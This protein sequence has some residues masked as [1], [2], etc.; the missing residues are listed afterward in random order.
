MSHKEQTDSTKSNNIFIGSFFKDH[1]LFVLPFGATYIFALIFLY[2]NYYLNPIENPSFYDI[3]EIVLTSF[4]PT[5]FS[6]IFVNICTNLINLVNM[7]SKNCIWNIVGNVFTVV[8]AF[9]YVF[10]LHNT[11]SIALIII[12]VLFTIVALLLN[13][14]GYFE[15]YEATARYHDFC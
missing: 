1:I 3:C 10:Y 7:G 5:T 8:Y 2:S 12:E 14:K 13:W 11:K 15:F 4:V 9:M 6:Y